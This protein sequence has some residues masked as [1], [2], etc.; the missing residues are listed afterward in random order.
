MKVVAWILLVLGTVSGGAQTVVLRAQKDVYPGVGAM[1]RVVAGQGVTAA[2]AAKMNVAFAKLD[3]RV[4][5]AAADCRKSYREQQHKGAKDAWTR[6][7]QVTMRGPRYLSLVATDSYD[8][9]G[10]YPN[11]GLILPLVYDL[12]TGG[13]VNWLTLMPPGPKSGIDSAGDGS[14]IGAVQWTLL[15]DMARKDAQPECREAFASGD[16]VS[17]VI[18]LDAKAGAVEAQPS[19]FPHAEAACADAVEIPVAE[20]RAMG[21]KA[22]L[23]D[24]LAAAGNAKGVS[25]R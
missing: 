16:E 6:S 8:C 19:S 11:D 25:P 4:A 9:G 21:F 24:A 15:T 17:F 5:A 13:A 1:P 23:V 14:T 18:W 20:A 7:V 3:M 22:E 2:V 10:P 12:T